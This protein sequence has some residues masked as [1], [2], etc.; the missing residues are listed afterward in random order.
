MFAVIDVD[1]FVI[2]VAFDVVVAAVF[3]CDND[4]AAVLIAMGFM[5]VIVGCVILRTMLMKWL[6]LW[7]RGCRCR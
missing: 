2:V 7:R 4:A 6:W 3:M 5:V 1:V